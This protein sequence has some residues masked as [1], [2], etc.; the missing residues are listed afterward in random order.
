MIVLTQNGFFAGRMLQNGT[1]ALGSHKITEEEIFTMFSALM[2]TF[3]KKTGQ[4]TLALPAGDGRAIIS[5]LVE[6]KRDPEQEQAA[7]EAA[8]KKGAGR[9][10]GSKQPR[11]K[12]KAKAKAGKA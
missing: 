12:A 4:D 11:P 1:L 3:C 8:P 6:V 5:K 7:A 2:R 9:K 10:Q